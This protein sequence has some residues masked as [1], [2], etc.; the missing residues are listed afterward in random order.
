MGVCVYVDGRRGVCGYGVGVY[1]CLGVRK[2]VCVCENV[3]CVV[4]GRE[5]VCVCL[6]VWFPLKY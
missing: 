5:G 4:G 6:C 3:L 1:V 2:G